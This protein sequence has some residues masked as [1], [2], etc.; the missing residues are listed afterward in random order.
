MRERTGVTG[1]EEKDGEKASDA[2]ELNRERER[3]EKSKGDRQIEEGNGRLLTAA[4]EIF[5]ELNCAGGL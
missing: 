2:E 4:A 5:Y 3:E 1:S